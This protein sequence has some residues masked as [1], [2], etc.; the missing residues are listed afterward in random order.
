MLIA[1]SRGLDID[2]LDG[3]LQRNEARDWIFGDALHSR[4]LPINYGAI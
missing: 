4:P 2:D 3:D 1:Y